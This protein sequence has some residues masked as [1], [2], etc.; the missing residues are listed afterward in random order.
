MNWEKLFDLAEK[1][2]AKKNEL[3]V[4]SGELRDFFGGDVRPV[5]P[6]EPVLLSKDIAR[7]KPGPKPRLLTGKRGPRAMIRKGIRREKIA[8]K[9]KGALHPKFEKRLAKN[10]G[11]SASIVDFLD[12]HP[13]GVFNAKEVSLATKHDAKA[14]GIAM[15]GL[16]SRGRIVRVSVGV[17]KTAADDSRG[18]AEGIIQDVVADVRDASRESAAFQQGRDAAAAGGG[19]D[20]Y[21][22]KD[23]TLS[24]A[25]QDGI[26][27]GEEP[28]AAAQ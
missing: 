25:F 5:L 14:V 28:K 23:E 9:S 12:T 18:N 17:Y 20:P 16:A 11:M 7:V 6:A 26:A 1:I 21:Q 22:G 24:K 19:V 10:T 15:N 13:T 3:F 2:T 8:G 4:L 27:G